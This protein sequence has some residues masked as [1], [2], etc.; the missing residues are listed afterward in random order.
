MKKKLLSLCVTGASLGLMAGT[1]VA[2]LNEGLIAYYPFDGDTK[3]A[4]ENGNHGEANG[5][6]SY[7]AGKIKQAARFDGVDDYI[8]I[9]PQSDVSQIGDFTIVAWVYL[10]GWKSHTDRQ[11]IFD[12][13]SHSSTATGGFLRPGFSLIYD[14]IDDREEI[15]N[16]IK[17]DGG[18]TE[19]N[20]PV[21]IS[22]LWH[23]LLYM[24]KGAE[25]FTYVDGQLLSA[26]Y[27]RQLAGDSPLN[28]AHN[29]FI[30]TFSGNNPHYESSISNYSFLGLIDELRIYNRALTEAEIEESYNSNCS[31]EPNCMATFSPETGQLHIPCVSVGTTVYD[32]NF[33]QRFGSYT[34]DLDLATVKPR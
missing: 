2:D 4:T 13:H 7:V 16:A 6:L 33:Q 34:F 20:T 28:M 19:Q 9:T 31:I 23:Q 17:S 15:H 29:W 8:E 22:G 24:R 11:Y 18:T 21:S 5:G 10:E 12:G 32:V 14:Q 27:S 30:G 1:A 26:T 3:D 25:D